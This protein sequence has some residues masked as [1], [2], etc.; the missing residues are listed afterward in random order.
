MS[1]PTPTTRKAIPTTLCIPSPLARM[2]L[3]SSP[4][5]SWTREPRKRASARGGEQRRTRY[6]RLTKRQAQTVSRWT[7]S[8][9]SFAKHSRFSPDCPAAILEPWGRR[10]CMPRC[11][12]HMFQVCT[13]IVCQRD[14]RRVH[15]ISG[16]P[17]S[18]PC[19][20]GACLWTR[21]CSSS[22]TPRYHP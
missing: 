8:A 10:V 6:A 11:S 13:M 12:L 18:T 9:A 2:L 1:S 19:C 3:W 21:P 5:L 16:A 7:I 15:R 17:A 4:L 22:L 14:T 20:P